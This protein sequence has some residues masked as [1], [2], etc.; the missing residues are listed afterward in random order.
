MNLGDGVSLEMTCGNAACTSFQTP[1]RAVVAGSLTGT[2]LLGCIEDPPPG[3]LGCGGRSSVTSIAPAPNG[4][5]WIQVSSRADH[6]SGAP[7]HTIATDAA[8]KFADVTT[9]GYLAAIPGRNGYFVVSL[10]GH[11]DSRSDAPDLCGGEL[12]NCS[13]YKPPAISYKGWIRSAA[14]TPDGKGLWAVTFD[15]RVYTAG[16]A[17][18]YGDQ[19]KQHADCAAI[20]ATPSEKGYYLLFEDGGV[21]TFGGAR[22][23]GSTGGKHSASIA[24]IS[25]LPN[26]HEYAWVTT[27]GAHQFG[28]PEFRKDHDSIGPDRKV[29]HSLDGGAR[30]TF[31][32]GRGLW[33]LAQPRMEYRTRFRRRT[34]CT[35]GQRCHRPMR[36][37]NYS[38]EL[39]HTYRVPMPE[40]SPKQR[41]VPAHL[42]RQQH[43]TDVPG[44]SLRG[45]QGTWG[46]DYY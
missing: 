29:D 31:E 14:A 9:A 12:K 6:G 17:L 38:G 3:L 35:F 21:S 36:Q 37:C 5:V 30:F 10:S 2:P 16:T 24:D 18:P 19:Q 23:L 15:G 27:G 11:I 20:V 43:G 13:S 41:V 45:C 46:S 28:D 42:H 1:Q 33:Q 26:R 44:D 7:G 40:D 8:P 39:L 4:G 32:F 22:F 25:A 34:D